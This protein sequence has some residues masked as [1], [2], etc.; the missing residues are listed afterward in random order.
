MIL[1]NI[2]NKDNFFLKLISYCP[3]LSFYVKE[4]V[5]IEAIIQESASVFYCNILSALK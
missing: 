2:A 1:S 5:K 3:P 4:N